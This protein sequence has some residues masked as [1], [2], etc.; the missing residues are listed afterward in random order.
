MRA[1]EEP[2]E[3]EELLRRHADAAD[4]AR[5]NTVEAE[6]AVLEAATDDAPLV[7]NRSVH[8]ILRLADGDGNL[9]ATYYQQVDAGLRTP[10]DSYWDRM[11][12]YA[13]QALFPGYQKDIRF[14]VLSP[15]GVGLSYYGAWAMVLKRD[16]VEHRS[17]VFER[18]TASWVADQHIDRIGDLR[19]LPLGRRGTWGDRS[20]LATVKLVRKLMPAMAPED[21]SAL[22]VQDP[23]TPDAEF[24]EVHVWGPITR[25]AIESVTLA[26]PGVSRIDRALNDAAAEKLRSAGV[27]VV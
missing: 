23:A 14:G 25:R 22:L 2:A 8:E 13:D 26:H 24:I 20:R 10:D 3:R 5:A 17:S 18:N 4:V 7:I 15:A 11:R 9:Y 16:M 1:A 21:I 6:L 19:D 12:W 27:K